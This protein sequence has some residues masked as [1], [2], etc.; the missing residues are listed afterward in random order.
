MSAKQKLANII[1]DLKH[2]DNQVLAKEKARNFLATINPAELSLAEEQLVAAGL[3]PDDL[4]QLCATHLEMM[5]EEVEQ[6]KASLPS[7]H[8]IHTMICEHEKILGFLDKL[9]E[10]NSRIQDAN[11]KEEVSELFAILEHIAKHLLAAEAHHKREEDVLF[12]E[13]ESRGVMGPPQ[14]MRH[15]HEN[16]RMRKNRLMVVAETANYGH[17]STFQTKL[18]SITKLLVPSLRE[19]ISKENNILYPMAIDLIKEEETWEQMK[20]ACDKI[21]YC[22]FTP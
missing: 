11:T 18:D 3:S 15:E 10:V 4:R 2:N 9:E 16:F 5:K 8:V 13:M 17:F 21:G 22:C 14:V 1:E 12:V 6:L 7:S 19:H 20:S